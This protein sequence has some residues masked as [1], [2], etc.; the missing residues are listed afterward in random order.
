MAFYQKKSSDKAHHR[1]LLVA[2]RGVFNDYPSNP[3]ALF[4]FINDG[5]LSPIQ[6]C[7]LAVNGNQ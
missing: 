1:N 2:H 7:T 4:L 5:H 6:K 3:N